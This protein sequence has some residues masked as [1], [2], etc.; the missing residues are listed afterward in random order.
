MKEK[1]LVFYDIFFT[2]HMYMYAYLYIYLF[3]ELF[4]QK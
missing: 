3:N 1:I 2:T 4:M